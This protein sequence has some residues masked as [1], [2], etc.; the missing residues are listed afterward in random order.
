MQLIPQVLPKVF[1]QPRAGHPEETKSHLDGQ[2]IPCRGRHL[3]SPEE[4]RDHLRV[5]Q[6]FLRLAVVDF[7]LLL[8]RLLQ[9]P[10]LHLVSGGGGARIVLVLHRAELAPR[11]LSAGTRGMRAGAHGL[12]PHMVLAA[13]I[14]LDLRLLL[15]LSRGVEPARLVRLA[16]RVR[17][18]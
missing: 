9:H 4:L 17:D 11:A 15:A 14:H 2:I 18:N 8:P 10:P 7:E 1:R 3:T 6:C 12:H 5:A 13:G 16:R